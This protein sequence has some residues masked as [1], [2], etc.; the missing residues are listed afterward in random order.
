MSGVIRLTRREQPLFQGDEKKFKT[1]VKQAFSQKR[2]TLR[3][4]LKGFVPT[5]KLH[6]ERFNRRAE[7]VP[8]AEFVSLFHELVLQ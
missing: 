2:K 6:D 5:E 7:Q 4:C 1:F 8:V 3:N